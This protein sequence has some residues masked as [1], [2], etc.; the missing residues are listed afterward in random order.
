MFAYLPNSLH[1]PLA[2]CAV[3]L[4]AL[5]AIAFGIRSS[6]RT[7]R[8]RRKRLQAQ[9]AM[10]KINEF[11]HP[12][13][14]LAYLRKIDPFA[15]EE[16][17]LDA[18]ERKGY[19]VRRNNRYTGDGGVDGV[20]FKDGR[21]YLIQAKRYAGHVQRAHIEQFCHLLDAKDCLG[22]FCHTG[23]TGQAGKDLVKAHGKAT[24]L[25]GQRLLDFL[26]V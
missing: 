5:L 3:L 22:F 20:V 7:R 23:K 21:R 6:V 2:I 4:I 24:V 12:G 14:R 25:S 9:K 11:E 26:S 10:A 1:L 13:Q 18:F 19:E 16:L 17:L 15:F 8:H